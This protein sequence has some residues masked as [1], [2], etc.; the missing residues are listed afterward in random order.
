MIYNEF[1][2]IFPP[3]KKFH[4]LNI[5]K[6]DSYNCKTKIYPDGSENSVI[7]SQAVFGGDPYFSSRRTL[8][9]D[10]ARRAF[11]QKHFKEDQNGQNILDI[12]SGLSSQETID[13]NNWLYSHNL[14]S[15]AECVQRNTIE[16]K[17]IKL[18]DS[19]NPYNTTY[20]RY[21]GDVR[22]DSLKRSKDRIFDYICCNTCDIQIYI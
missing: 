19:L 13:N 4:E 14:L 10:S 1:T 21:C 6:P 2:Q 22:D 20:R 18:T 8:S 12:L 17:I 15:A 11:F 5:I 16:R 7:H 9:D 3:P